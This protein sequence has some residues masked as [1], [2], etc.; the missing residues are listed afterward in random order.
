MKTKS[1]HDA[2]LEI[3]RN[4]D[5]DVPQF[6][7]DAEL[8]RFETKSGKKPL[9]AIGREFEYK[10][11]TF[12]VVKYGD[13]RNGSVY[14]WK[15]YDIKKQSKQFIKK[16]RETLDEIAA[17]ERYETQ[18]KNENCVKNWH[19]KFKAAKSSDEIHPYLDEKG[20]SSNHTA[21]TDHNGTLLIPAYNHNGF[22]GCQLIFKSN[23]SGE[24]IKRFTSGIKLKGSIC[25]I[26][27]IRDAKYIYVAEGFATAATIYEATNIPCVVVWNCNN[28]YQG[29]QTI[30]HINPKCRIIIAADKDIKDKSKDISIKKAIFCKKRFSNILIKWPEFETLDPDL[31]DFNDLHQ[32]TD[33]ETVKK[34]LEFSDSDFIS[35]ELLGHDAKK[36]HYFNSQSMELKS[37]TVNEHNELNLLSMAN[38]K[39][40]GERY[41]FKK[42]KEGNYTDQADFRYA[43]EK[44]FEEQRANGFFNFQNVRGYGSWID[45]G[46]IVV[47]LGDRQIVDNKFVENVPD[48][49]YLYVSNFPTPIDWD[50]PLTD[51][52]CRKIIDLFKMFNYKNSGDYIYLSAFVALAQVFNAVDWRFQLWITGS[53]GSG[54]TEIMKMM[55][56]LVFDSEIYQSVTGASIRQY[57]KQDAMPMLIDEAEPNCGETRKR[58]DGVIELIRQCSSRMNNK[59][60]RGTASGQVMEYNV[61]SIFCLA[62][63][64]PYLPTQADV[65]RFFSVEMN[66]NKNSE[67]AVWHEIQKRFREVENFAPRLFARMV[68]MIPILRK[69]IDT[70]KELLVDSD[71]LK[72]PRQADQ[73]S[74]AFGAYFALIS[75][76]EFCNDDYEA[77]KEMILETNLGHSEYEEE[78]EVDEAEN[79]FAAIM[80]SLTVDRKAT[81]AETIQLTKKDPLNKF[82]TKD[83]ATMGMRYLHDK[84]ELFIAAS[85]KQLRKELLGTMYH[86]YAKVLKR[87]DAFIRYSN[88]R[89]H[90]QVKKGVYLEI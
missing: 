57:L 79:C 81:I 56:K 4:L 43:I 42:D 41:R 44:M 32:V 64:Q 24:Y 73:I 58:M 30:R 28:M 55:A 61:N 1:I 75:K 85:N 29:I 31:T 3:S 80:E 83:L 72:D 36:Y 20:I 15:N 38:N 67:I 50:N 88:C 84:K 78:N 60:L 59:T 33:L 48:T 49:K 82:Y 21:K 45:N 39:Y 47:N 74:T 40:W 70:I 17:K 90:G 86:D 65:S 19:P 76:N 23:E 22:V 10:G 52:E 13:W 25:P 89:I 6:P 5:F 11:N 34:Q 27:K 12:A 68:K 54:K 62:S 66:S 87:H 51:Q 2:Y 26:G 9:W 8:K 7:F 37:L 18:K 71:F 63:I 77:L 46:R 16:Q 69:N 14:T 35:I 53:R